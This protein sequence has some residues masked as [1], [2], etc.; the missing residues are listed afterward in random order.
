MDIFNRVNS[1]GTKLS[2]GDLALARICA[3]RPAARE[4]L[5]DIVE[6]WHG[7][8]FDFTLDW[9]L[10]C[11]N[12]VATGEARFEAMKN[13]SAEDFGVAV[14][15]AEHSIDFLLNLVS[16]RLGLDHDRVLLGRYG[17]PALVKFTVD[18]GGSVK[19]TSTQNRLLYWYVHRGMWGRYSSSTESTL[20][21][22]LAALEERGLDGLIA[23][24]ELSRGTL[25]VR[26]DDFDT[27]TIG[28]RFYPVLY[29]LTRVNDA[30][31]FCTGLPLSKHLL[32]KGSNL[33]VHHVFPKAV[34]YEADFTRRQVNAVANFAFLTGSSNRTLGKR[35]PMDYFAEVAANHDGALTS[36][37]V[38]EDTA[39]RSTDRYLDFLAARRGLLAEAA[40]ALLEGLHEGELTKAEVVGVGGAGVSDEPDDVLRALSNWCADLGL[41]RPDIS[42]EIVDEETGEPLV[43]PDAAWPEGMQRGLVEKIALLLERDEE[44]ESRL[45]ELGY[46]FFTSRQSLEHYVEELLNIDLDGDG[47]IGPVGLDDDSAG[48]G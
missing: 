32:G 39:L 25:Q 20:D 23:E 24:L 10:R 21:R 4:E 19:D 2:K 7:A 44:A 17:F 12:V 18:A 6:R 36:Q 34:L 38:P 29:M 41:A 16:T 22:D 42:G 43:Y 9:F 33:E 3:I 14:K 45:G 15:K 26:P 46:R 27:Q 13:L 1:G 47:V 28:S 48:G 5:R 8:G 37:W 31:D 40:N 35:P 30:K 11:V